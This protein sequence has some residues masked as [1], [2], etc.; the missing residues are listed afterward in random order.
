MKL[1]FDYIAKEYTNIMTKNG[2]R[3]VVVKE[4]SKLKK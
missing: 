1:L 4:L 2:Q 3:D